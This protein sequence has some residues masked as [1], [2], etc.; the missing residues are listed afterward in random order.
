MSHLQKVYV[1]WW[2]KYDLSTLK[3]VGMVGVY[4]NKEDAK[5]WAREFVRLEKDAREE[6]IVEWV[7]GYRCDI[8]DTQIQTIIQGTRVI[9]IE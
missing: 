9:A 5:A 1:V 4:H 7:R 3:D 2:K 8:G 6:D